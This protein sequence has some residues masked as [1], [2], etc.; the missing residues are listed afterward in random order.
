MIE[1]RLSFVLENEEGRPRGLY[2]ATEGTDLPCISQFADYRDFLR[3]RLAFEKE[4]NSNLSLHYFA[5]KLKIS[6]AF[7]SVLLAKKKH[8]S[9]ETLADVSEFLKLSNL[10]RIVLIFSV[11]ELTSKSTTQAE[12]FG[13]MRLQVTGIQSF[14]IDLPKH[15][16]AELSP[17]YSSELRVVLNGLAGLPDFRESP[18]W[19]LPRLLA[20]PE[21]P[22]Q[23]MTTLR[24]VLEARAK[25]GVAQVDGE[26]SSILPYSPESVDVF[27]P[28][29]A[30]VGRALDHADEMFPYLFLSNSFRFTR[31]AYLEAFGEVTDLVKKLRDI[32]RRHPGG[33]RVM[34]LGG[35]LVTVSKPPKEP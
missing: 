30:L 25:V 34:Q 18:E 1:V 10:D 31:A 5:R 32:E 3:E 11:L 29:H 6:A 16:T 27:R 2:R 4:R 12:Y 26:D 35:G 17:L 23:I 15:S 13:Y 33:D 9:L 8:L 21:S 24:E 22:G 19:V 20:R 28:G 7:L 14:G